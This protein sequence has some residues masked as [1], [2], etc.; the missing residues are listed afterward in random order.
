[1]FSMSLCWIL[2]KNRHF[3]P[4]YYGFHCPL[5]KMF[6]Q[7]QSQFVLPT[8]SVLFLM[9]DTKLVYHRQTGMWPIIPLY[10]CALRHLHRRSISL[11]AQCQ[12]TCLGVECDLR[13]PIPR[14]V[15]SG[16]SQ[17]MQSWKTA[18]GWQTTSK[19]GSN[20]A[21]PPCLK[22]IQCLCCLLFHQ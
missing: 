8:R 14:S 18:C 16:A 17:M 13:S 10:N 19:S 3:F 12:F 4:I 6:V 1:M 7:I 15:I 21:C 11:N 5:S 2:G 22:I 9:P 20:N